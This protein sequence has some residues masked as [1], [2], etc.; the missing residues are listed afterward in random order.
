M[1]EINKKYSNPSTVGFTT[2]V[3]LSIT[4]LS[5]PEKEDLLNSF[6]ERVKP[7]GWW[8]GRG[9][10]E[11]ENTAKLFWSWLGAIVMTYATLFAM[12]YLIFQNWNLFFIWLAVACVGA[13]VVAKTSASSFK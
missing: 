10:F 11:T 7:Q 13:I 8:Q 4:F 12:G 1:G 5:R 9:N 2:L 6:F 3:W